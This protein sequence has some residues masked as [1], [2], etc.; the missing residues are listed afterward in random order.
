MSI[1]S[2]K[3][4]FQERL[5]EVVFKLLAV[6]YILIDSKSE[7]NSD[8]NSSSNSSSSNNSDSVDNVIQDQE[9]NYIA[10]STYSLVN[11]YIIFIDI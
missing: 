5:D 7:S 2:F 3:E 8:S 1:T 11:N 6:K 10:L 9:I 4:T